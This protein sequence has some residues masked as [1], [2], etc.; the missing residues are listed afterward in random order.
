MHH[1]VNSQYDECVRFSDVGPHLLARNMCPA[2]SKVY[3]V[4]G[5]ARKMQKGAVIVLRLQPTR[6]SLSYRVAYVRTITLSRAHFR[7][8]VPVCRL[9]FVEFSSKSYSV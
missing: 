8:Y 1:S 2:Y 4:R 6:R 5:L 9:S 3:R 7:K